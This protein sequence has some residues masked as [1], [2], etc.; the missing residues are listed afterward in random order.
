MTVRFL[1]QIAGGL[2]R[3]Q[4]PRAVDEGASDGNALL[5]PARQPVREGGRPVTHADRIE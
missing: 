3:K 2:V 4:Q 1:I 5:L